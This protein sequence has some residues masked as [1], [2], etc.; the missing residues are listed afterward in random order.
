MAFS[1][2]AS[3]RMII[4]LLPP[5]SRAKRGADGKRRPKILGRYYQMHWQFRS[6]PHCPERF[7][8]WTVCF[9]TRII[10]SALLSRSYI[11]SN[12]TSCSQR[13]TR[14][15]CSAYTTLPARSPGILSSSNDANSCLFQRRN[16]ARSAP[17]QMVYG[18]AHSIAVRPPPVFREQYNPEQANCFPR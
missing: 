14:R 16:S 8:R 2:A 3:S 7:G 13:R 9:R 17:R 5:N 4:V 1:M 18:E 6:L 12:T 11:S 15:P 10:S